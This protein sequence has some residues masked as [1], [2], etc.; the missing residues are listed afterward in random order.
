MVSLDREE[1]E[2][3]DHGARRRSRRQNWQSILHTAVVDVVFTFA[4]SS[5]KPGCNV[6][7]DDEGNKL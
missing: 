7:E 2:A 6:S 3:Q 4:L 5:V 1:L